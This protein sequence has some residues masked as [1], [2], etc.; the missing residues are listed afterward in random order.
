MEQKS[1]TKKV[2][3]VI[4]AI[5]FF[6]SYIPYI[7]IISAGIEGVQRGLIGGPY[8]FGFEAM[9]NQLLWGCVIPVFPACFIYQMVFGI[10]YVRKRRILSVATL[11]IVA[12]IIISALSVGFSFENKK[13][14]IIKEDSDTIRTYLAEKYGIDPDSVTNIRV[15][16]YD[17]RSY[18]ATCDVL[19]KDAEFIVYTQLELGD[20]LKDTFLFYNDGFMDEFNAYLDEKY[21]FPDNMHCQANV[22]SIDFGDYKN[23]DDFAVLF[24]RIEYEIRGIEVELPEVNDD[25]LND[26]LQDIWAD[27]SLVIEP[28]RVPKNQ[29][30]RDA[31]D[32]Y[33][34][35]YI[36]V[37]GQ[38]A[39]S[40]EVIFNVYTSNKGT[41]LISAYSD[42][43]GDTDLNNGSI[44]LKR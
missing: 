44:K 1:T 33:Y 14:K 39:F 18:K 27:Q 7:S 11:V 22:L 29:F 24:D 3:G 38:Y 30:M 42:Y 5:I 37:N 26:V 36:K 15:D 40:A 31:V 12:A 43:T 16:V 4:G 41:A 32:S 6:A 2:F 23:G 19:P 20:S 8:V 17:D 13:S 34:I 9:Q 28:T 10:A 25:I 35:V 21:D